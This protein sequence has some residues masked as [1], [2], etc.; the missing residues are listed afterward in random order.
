MTVEKE[1]R[2]WPQ[3]EQAEMFEEKSFI[4][5]K[6]REEK[7]Q[8]LK[9]CQKKK[10]KSRYN[11]V[12]EN[13]ESRQNQKVKKKAWNMQQKGRYSQTQIRAIN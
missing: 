1:V 4:S 11:R 10:E 2:Q 12:K 7:K 9:K 8:K 6:Q 13:Q 5:R 3:K